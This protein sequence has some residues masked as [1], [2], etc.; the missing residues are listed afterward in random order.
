MRTNVVIYY[1]FE[2]GIPPSRF[3]LRDFSLAQN[4]E[5]WIMHKEYFDKGRDHRGVFN[6]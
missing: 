6:N 1:M 2:A 5:S 4:D 3:S